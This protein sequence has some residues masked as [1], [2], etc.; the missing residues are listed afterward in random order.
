MPPSALDLD[1]IID[2]LDKHHVRAT[3][4]AV[5]DFVGAN[6][7]SV[8]AGYPR[9]PRYSWVVNQRTLE[10]TDYPPE[11]IHLA[12][13]S[14]SFVIMNSRELLDWLRRKGVLK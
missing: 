4:G 11:Q 8:M 6:P 5:A 14:K 7:Q 1:D 13:R 12:L 10:P 2:L 3:Y 9:E